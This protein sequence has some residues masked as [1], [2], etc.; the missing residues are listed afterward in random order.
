MNSVIFFP[1]SFVRMQFAKSK[2]NPNVSYEKMLH[3]ANM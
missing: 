3:F 2:V 1:T